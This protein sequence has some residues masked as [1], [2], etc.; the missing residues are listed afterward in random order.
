MNKVIRYTLIV[1][2]ILAL[3][4]SVFF[5]GN[6]YARAT[7]YGTTGM[8]GGYGWK[9]GNNNGYGPGMMNGSRT[10][11]G[12]MG[13]QGGYGT[14]PGMMGGYGNNNASVTPLTLDEAKAAAESYLATL[15]NPDLKISEI[16]IFDNN[17]YVVVT[18]A[19]T[20]LG[21]F[22]LLVDPASR[23]AYPEYGPNIMWNLKYGG[24]N[25]QNMMGGRGGMMNGM[26]GGNGLSSAI[27][28]G[29][30]VDMT[31]S[32]EKA[33]EVAQAYL[34]A[35]LAGATA[36]TDPVQFYGYYTLDFERDGVVA[37]MLSV[38]GYSGQVFLH[39]WHGKFIEEKM[40]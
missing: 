26:M 31:V 33:I 21:A 19:S 24:L 1:I 3:A 40:Y 15:N 14:G 25:H 35:N 4:G 36:A 17:A 37:G 39:T 6:M 22:E 38:N 13:G 10:G 20:G 30:S 7:G 5:A 23:T 12:M 2:A 9:T 16:M 28:A 29:V 11:Y 8:M 27:P 32:P 18:E 34:D